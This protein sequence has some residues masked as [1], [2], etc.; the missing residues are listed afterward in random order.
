MADP[1]V[2]GAVAASLKPETF[3]FH[4]RDIRD[5]KDE[6]A[7]GNTSVARAKK[8]AKRDGVKLEVLKFVEMLNEMD[9]D[10][11]EL[12]INTA[13]MYASWLKM[14]LGAWSAG[15]EVTP[16]RASNQ[17]DFE[18]WQAGQEG[19][20]AGLNGAQREHNPYPAGTEKHVAWDKKWAGGFRLNQ[21][22]LAD[23]MVKG[24]GGARS[25][26]ENGAS[27]AAH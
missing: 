21:R 24:T 13:K 5:A 18:K 8:A 20:K 7:T 10:E 6:A 23:K 4:F 27:A 2:A 17:A 22:K 19:Q 15:I 9:E 26:P 16:P 12:F 14:P 25:R 11:A 3:L 1:A